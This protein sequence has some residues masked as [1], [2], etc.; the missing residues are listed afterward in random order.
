M[1]FINGTTTERSEKRR[2]LS[3]AAVLGAGTFFAKLLGALY[4]IPLTALLGGT[5]IGLY[6]LVFPAYTVMLDFSGA[7]APSA[8]SKLIACENED[9][10]E[11]RA[12]D[13]LAAGLRLFAALGAIFSLFTFVFSGILARAQ[14]DENAFLSYAAIAPAIFLVCLI[15]PFRGYFQGLMDMKPTAV[16]QIT[17]Q[18]VKLVFG[19]FFVN[20]FMPNVPLAAAG[21]ALAIT[22]SEGAAAVYLYCAYKKRNKRLGVRFSL[23]KADNSFLAKRLVKTA[24]PITLVGVILPLSA[25][26]DSFIVVNSLSAYRS[27]AT[28]LYGLFSGVATTIVGLPVAVCYGVAAVAIPAVSGAS[29][30]DNERK[31][32]KRTILL[33]LALS[34][35]CALVLF[36][37]APNVINILFRSISEEER[38]ISATLLKIL[39]PAA[40]LLSLLQTQ[41]AVLIAKNRLY[42]P[43]LSMATGAAAKLLIE[44][45]LVKNPSVNVYGCGFAVIACYFI[46]DLINFIALKKEKAPYAAAHGLHY[47][48]KTDTN[49]RNYRAE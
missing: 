16:S 10:R 45:A 6:Q 14:G 2:I 34:A 39:S 27:D 36:I 32:A 24:V 43:I 12:C 3:G 49:R 19:L 42:A 28:A 20:L 25:M 47:A 13:Y 22:V 1:S 38:E 7:G 8:L 46:A 5:G 17:E 29:G 40:T 37:F 11:R 31:N 44:I 4:R 21:A 26:A 33:T 35:P 15:T 18:L 48:D 30:R 23:D 41:N 9:I